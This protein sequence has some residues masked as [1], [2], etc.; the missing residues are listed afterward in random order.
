MVQIC[1]HW[2]QYFSTDAKNKMTTFCSPRS[3]CGRSHP[4]EG[5]QVGVPTPAAGRGCACRLRHC[6][7]AYCPSSLNSHTIVCILPVR[8]WGFKGLQYLTQVT[9]EQRQDLN[10]SSLSPGPES[11]C[12]VL[13][14][15]A[16]DSASIHC[17]ELQAPASCAYRKLY[18]LGMHARWHRNSTHSGLN[19]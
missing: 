5:R 9:Q 15:A 14:V 3:F 10:P 11:D 4:W 7:S 17:C 1:F 19:K 6:P 2:F 8:K 12:K 13:W 18:P 16:D